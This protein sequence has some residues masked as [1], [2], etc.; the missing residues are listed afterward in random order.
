[1]KTFEKE[2][3]L[4]TKLETLDQYIRSILK[5][6]HEKPIKNLIFCFVCMESNS[7]KTEIYVIDAKTVA[8]IVKTGHSIH[9]KLPGL[10]GQKHKNT[11]MRYLPRGKV[12]PGIERRK[13]YKKYLNK[14][15]L[16]FLKK[17]S[18]GWIDKYKEAWHL[19]G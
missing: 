17:Y 3:S 12:F 13:N 4:K 5:E 9:L 7:N 15:D 1:M 16:V 18:E 19:I 14:S 6:K 10:K 2:F 8:N 11:N